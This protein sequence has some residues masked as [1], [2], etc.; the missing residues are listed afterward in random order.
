MTEAQFIYISKGQSNFVRVLFLRNIAYGKFRR[1]KT[2]LK[3]L[4]L[5]YNRGVNISYKLCVRKY[6]PVH[7]IL[8]LTCMLYKI[9]LSHLAYRVNSKKM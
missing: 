8:G 7:E 5:Q 6:A 3:F 2:L 9:I 1:N 4:N